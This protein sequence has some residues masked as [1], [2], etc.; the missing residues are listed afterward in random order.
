[1]IPSNS[2]LLEGGAVDFDTGGTTYILTGIKF[3][4][5]SEKKTQICYHK[6]EDDNVIFFR[7]QKDVSS[8]LDY[9]VFR[10]NIY[11]I[12]ESPRG[13]L[14]LCKYSQHRKQFIPVTFSY[15]YPHFE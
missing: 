8:Y 11:S 7:H 6:G 1:M 3:E 2:S 9:F 5:E 4:V 13:N 10:K 15:P 14:S 12:K